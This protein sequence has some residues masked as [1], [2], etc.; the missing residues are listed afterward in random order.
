VTQR[1]NLIATMLQTMRSIRRSM[2]LCQIVSVSEVPMR[3]SASARCNEAVTEA[4]LFYCR[5]AVTEQFVSDERLMTRFDLDIATRNCPAAP[6][7]QLLAPLRAIPS[8]GTCSLSVV[9]ATPCS[10]SGL[11][12]SVRELVPFFPLACCSI[13]VLP[14]RCIEV[15]VQHGDDVPGSISPQ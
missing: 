3:R 6:I 7:W 2:S 8:H 12:S 11:R 13:F 14:V 15:E 9:S 10:A 1:K 4:R 5:Y